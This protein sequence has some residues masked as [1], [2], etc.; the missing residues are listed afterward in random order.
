MYYESIANI[1]FMIII[2]IDI[3]KEKYHFFISIPYSTNI[4]LESLSSFWTFNSALQA[5]KI[6]RYY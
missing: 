2:R 6:N 3:K 1:N 5:M 4:I